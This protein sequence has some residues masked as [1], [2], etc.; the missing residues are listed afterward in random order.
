[1]KV[2]ETELYT[3]NEDLRQISNLSPLH[4]NDGIQFDSTI[5]E[6]PDSKDVTLEVPKSSIEAGGSDN[7][8]EMPSLTSSNQI[9]KHSIL[10]S[11][12]NP[13]MVPEKRLVPYYKTR[14]TGQKHFVT[15]Q[16]A[17]ADFRE[18]TP[19]KLKIIN[20]AS[21]EEIRKL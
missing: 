9:T 18:L 4:A 3:T 1:M 16:F 14:N 20:P 2:I 7:A 19:I 8:Q 13:L 11:F 6:Q 5:I 12:K 15:D 17:Q 21:P 10:M